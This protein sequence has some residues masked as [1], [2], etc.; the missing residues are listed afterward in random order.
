MK[1]FPSPGNC[2]TGS[3]SYTG[4]SIGAWRTGAW[5]RSRW[6]QGGSVITHESS[7]TDQCHRSTITGRTPIR[8]SL[9]LHRLDQIDRGSVKLTEAPRSADR[10]PFSPLTW[11]PSHIS[12]QHS[13]APAASGAVSSLT[14]GA[15]KG[16]GGGGRGHI[17]CYT[18]GFYLNKNN[19]GKKSTRARGR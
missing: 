4:T 1:G 6:K 12:R 19:S 18:D 3:T 9:D 13:A 10:A 16:G 5:R 7:V 14:Y 15:Y 8:R 17:I 11:R 2:V